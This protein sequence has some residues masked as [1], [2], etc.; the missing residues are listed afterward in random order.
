MP[1]FYTDKIVIGWS[2]LVGVSFSPVVSTTWGRSLAAVL[3]ESASLI[4]S[5]LIL[6]LWNFCTRLIL[7]AEKSRGG[8]GLGG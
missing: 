5:S 8:L 4:F 2:A 6:R 1:I 7:G 3:P